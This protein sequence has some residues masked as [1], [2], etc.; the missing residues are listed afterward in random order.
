MAFCSKFQAWSGAPN[1][2][3]TGFHDVALLAGSSYR[4]P[5]PHPFSCL[6]STTPSSNPTGNGTSA[7]VLNTAASVPW[8]EVA[9]SNDLIQVSKSKATQVLCNFQTS[10]P[11]ADIAALAG[12]LGEALELKLQGVA[13]LVA[14][15]PVFQIQTHLLF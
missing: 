7:P 8:G 10:T 6:Q 14:M 4:L 5:S 15:C 1:A 13:C 11:D 3:T 12:T 2:H 9:A